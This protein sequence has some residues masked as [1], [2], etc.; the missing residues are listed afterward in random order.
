MVVKTIVH[1]EIPADNVERLKNFYS[2]VFGWKFDKAP[3]PD[4][5]YWMIRTGPAGKRV[6][7][8]LYKKMAPDERPRNYVGVDSVDESAAA[9]KKAGG[10]IIV[11]KQEVPGQGWSV[12]AADPEGNPIALWQAKVRQRRTRPK[13]RARSSRR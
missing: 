10:T 2:E 6:G 7:I 12:I 5:E 4:F 9:L 11:E 8:G 1:F 3:M 13:K